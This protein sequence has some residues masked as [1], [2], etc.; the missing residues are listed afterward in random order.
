[1]K[2]KLLTVFT[3]VV[4]SALQPAII[5]AQNKG[6]TIN[7]FHDAQYGLFFHFLPT[8]KDF[9]PNIDRF[10]V[11]EFVKDCKESGAGYVIFT[12]GQ[13]SGYENAPNAVYDNYTGHKKGERCST[14]NLPME[15]AK[16]LNREN[17]GF[18]LYIPGD[19][20]CDDSVAA[21]HLGGKIHLDNENGKNWVLNNT[22]VGRWAEVV[23][24]WSKH[25]G[26]LV[27]GWWFDG[28]YTKS[29]FNDRYASMFKSAAKS[30][31]PG[32]I[33]SFNSG[34]NYDNVG[35]EDYLAGEERDILKPVCPGRWVSGAQWHELSF[36][37]SDWGT[38]QPGV[39]AEQLASHIKEVNQ[40]G[41]V[42]T[43]DCKLNPQY[44][45]WRIDSNHLKVLKELN[46][47]L[48]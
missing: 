30:G 48:H 26:S 6:I 25:Y 1:M 15:I 47:L 27:R 2:T 17:I 10:S 46:V 4:W 11:N 18:L 14:R 41:G 33:V 20:P 16:A 3:L 43:I 5:C 32:A 12:M 8:G 31:N 7:W 24:E 36:L 40:H 28:C 29:G 13:N 34:L 45:G 44:V 23:R 21:E 9:Q 42:I 39:T 37:G 38:G 19:V 35:H 22:S